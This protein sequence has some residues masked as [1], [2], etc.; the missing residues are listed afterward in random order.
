MTAGKYT[1]FMKDY[2]FNMTKVD[3]PDASYLKN[4]KLEPQ[5]L[6]P[7][8]CEEEPQVKVSY[9]RLICFASETMACLERNDAK[10]GLDIVELNHETKVHKVIFRLDKKV[11]VVL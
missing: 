10:S 6:I 3:R 1:V 2:L 4:V 9:K 8:D 7:D 11:R 5:L